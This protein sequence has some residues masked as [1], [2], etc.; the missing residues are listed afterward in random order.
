MKEPI[1]LSKAWVRGQITILERQGIQLTYIELESE[2]ESRGE[3][4]APIE[5]TDE[6]ELAQGP[7]KISDSEE[8]VPLAEKAKKVKKATPKV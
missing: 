1:R 6:A 3:E 4:D 8:H 5:V 7:A 2:K